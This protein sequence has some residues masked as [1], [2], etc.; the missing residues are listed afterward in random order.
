MMETEVCK[1]RD[2]SIGHNKGVQRRTFPVRDSPLDRTVSLGI[3]STFAGQDTLE[4]EVL[5]CPLAACGQSHCDLA[6][7]C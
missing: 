4:W 5:F 7:Q 2:I 1:L 6:M 3:V